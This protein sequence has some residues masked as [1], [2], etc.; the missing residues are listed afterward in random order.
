MQIWKMM[1]ILL[2]VDSNCFANDIKLFINME[3]TKE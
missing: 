3:I 2:V 1:K